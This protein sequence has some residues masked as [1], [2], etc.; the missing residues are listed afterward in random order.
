MSCTDAQRIELKRGATLSL[1][2][3]ATLPA[4][5]WT[6]TCS[7][8]GNSGKFK[9]MLDVALTPPVSPA[10]AHQ[11]MVSKASSETS[12]WPEGD[13]VCD[14]R[15]ADADGVVIPTPSFILCIPPW[16]THG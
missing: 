6:A 8:T 11:I 5:S 16:V 1:A 15:F 12:A 7:A 9:T 3:T 13:L 4:G 10:T 2:G 14:I